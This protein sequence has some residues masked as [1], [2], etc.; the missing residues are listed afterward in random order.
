M[1]YMGIERIRNPDERAQRGI[2]LAAFDG[3]QVRRVQVRSDGEFRP[4]DTTLAAQCRDPK[5]DVS[6]RLL[7]IGWQ[8]LERHRTA[9]G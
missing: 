5:A 2:A 7:L 8:R 6:E 1:T 9:R 4:R 3:S